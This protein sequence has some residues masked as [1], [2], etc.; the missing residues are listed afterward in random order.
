MAETLKP[1]PYATPRRIPGLYTAEWMAFQ[2]GLPPRLRSDP[3]L[4]AFVRRT[5]RWR[6]IAL[7]GGLLLPY[8]WILVAGDNGP[9]P[10]FF[11]VFVA[12]W[13]AA[14]ILP[15][16]FA[17]HRAAPATRVAT[18]GDRSTSRFVPCT[19]RRWLVGSFVLAAAAATAGR[20]WPAE[21]FREQLGPLALS[22]LV[23]VVS[24]TAVVRIAWRSHPAGHPDDVLV[25]DA[26][27]VLA[28]TTVIAAW[29]ALQF[30]ITLWMIPLD[31]IGGDG[32]KAPAEL[33]IGLSYLPVGGLI[34]AC[35]WV[36]T[37]VERERR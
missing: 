31:T 13:F 17:R 20:V 29:A 7:V 15:E 32:P 30:L 12:A 24:T 8:A 18:L 5:K 21:P 26:I 11:V 3:A 6:R 4:A 27:R 2:S 35:A 25:D 16:L 14:R 37:R 34:A 36:P 10:N 23:G 19:G 33:L 1:R 9:Y 22:L 28:T